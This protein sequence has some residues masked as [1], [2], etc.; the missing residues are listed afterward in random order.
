M[1]LGRESIQN[2]YQSLSR[3]SHQNLRDLDF[4]QVSRSRWPFHLLQLDNSFCKASH[5]SW[6]EKHCTQKAYRIYHH[7]WSQQWQH[8]DSFEYRQDGTLGRHLDQGRSVDHRSPINFL[9]K[10]LSALRDSSLRRYLQLL[11]MGLGGQR[12][13]SLSVASWQF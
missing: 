1:T 12:T 9:Q 13:L 6:E 7:G 10:Y 8:E 5:I 2:C 4:S 3:I 11:A